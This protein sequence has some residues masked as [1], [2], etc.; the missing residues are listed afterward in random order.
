MCQKGSSMWQK[1]KS[2]FSHVE[3]GLTCQKKTLL[4]HQDSS[5]RQQ[6]HD[7]QTFKFLVMALINPIDSDAL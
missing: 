4:L 7:V 1:R 6:S 3:E 5:K 2:G